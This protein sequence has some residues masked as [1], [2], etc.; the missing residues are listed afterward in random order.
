MTALYMPKD[1]GGEEV[2]Q[3]VNP[4]I[5][6][7]PTKTGQPQVVRELPYRQNHMS[8]QQGMPS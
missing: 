2:A 3:G 6:H 5:G 8:S 4:V 7:T 1:L